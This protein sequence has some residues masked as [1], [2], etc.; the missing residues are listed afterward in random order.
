MRPNLFSIL[1]NYNFY[2]PRLTSVNQQAKIKYDEDAYSESIPL[3][4]LVIHCF[5][6]DSLE[7][8]YS[9]ALLETE[10]LTRYV[11]SNNG[12]LPQAK[13]KL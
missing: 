8:G 11:Q 7:S 2:W 9:P 6:L 5:L 1:N 13:S 4:Q 3:S 10:I 12:D